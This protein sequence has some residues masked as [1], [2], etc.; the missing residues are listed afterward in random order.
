MILA[1]NV[2]SLVKSVA[3]FHIIQDL[4]FK[5]LLYKK[6]E[7]I[8]NRKHDYCLGKKHWIC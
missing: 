3:I 7:M 4:R 1:E 2:Y 6:P 8:K 5:K